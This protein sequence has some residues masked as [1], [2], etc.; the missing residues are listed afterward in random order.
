[1]M[2]APK[3]GGGAAPDLSGLGRS[4]ARLEHDRLIRGRGRYLDDIERP[5]QAHAAFLRSP[6]AHGRLLHIDAAEARALPGVHAVY[7]YADLRAALT[8][9]RIPTA[10]P[11]GSIRF[12]VDPY[13]LS[14]D[15][16]CHVGEPIALVLAESRHVAEDAIALIEVDIEPL[17]VVVDPRAGLE[18]GAPIARQDCPD[19]L[20]AA[21]TAEY[22]D[23]DAAFDGA[24]H[25][26]SEKFHLH[27]GG[28]HSLE[29]RGVVAEWDDAARHLT[30]WDS[31]QMPHRAK[32]ILC[33]SLGLAEDQ[34]R[35][36][37]PDVGGAFGPKFVFHPEELAIPAAA[38]L[39]GRPVKWVEDRFE[40][41]TATVQERD[42]Y[43]TVELAADAE[44][45]LLGV[46]GALIHDHGAYSPYG[47]ALPY[48]SATNLIGP[49]VLP[50]YRLNISLCM[51]N[52]IPSTPTRGAGRPQGTFV[53]ERLLDR[54]AARLGLGRDE[55]RRRNLIAAEKLPYP[56]G[57]RTRDGGE[58]TY[59]S[60]DYVECQRRVLEAADWDGFEA[61]REA[62]AREGRFLG[63][64]LANY[65]EGS[66][67]GPFE[68]ATVS[69]GPS[70][71][72]SVATGA[73]AQGQGTATMLAQLAAARL[74]AEPEDVRIVAG[75]TD[76][77]PN[78]LGAFASRQA[79]TAGNAV[80][81]AAGQV[82]EKLLSVASL[83][84]NAAPEELVLEG[85]VISVAADPE[86]QCA[87][88][89]I[90]RALSGEP[91]YPLPQG[92]APGLSASVDF[93][94]PALT[95]CNGAHVAE[96]EVCPETGVGK[97]L[98]Y[99]VVHD[100]GRLIHPRMVEG[101]ITGGVVHG[102]SSA[103]YEWMGYDQNGQPQTVT[104]ADYLIST[105]DVSPRIEIHHM[106]SPTPLNPL[107]V[108]GAG[109]SGTIA[110]PAAIA[111]A[112]EDALRP[113]GV[114]ITELP[115]TPGRLSDLVRRGRKTA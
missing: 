3:A 107:G 48:N 100:C 97:I 90:A 84:L 52:L 14:C 7:L 16:V 64:G 58:M 43:W 80:H 82:R 5:G 24:A 60:G 105:A 81:L 110:A 69:I 1:M 106:E 9:D 83:W 8:T 112:F 113:F 88:S 65:V 36:I 70:G 41:F 22:G 29:P 4:S 68:S 102:L 11:S 23:V 15:E 49:Y 95:Y 55:L 32:R 61:R 56:T 114:A 21:I 20:V 26:I 2:T 87:V 25:V 74:G 54:L 27:K 28:G 45:R 63:I 53:M 71:R 79:V 108:K 10:M 62:A 34:V 31:T 44:G 78:G 93:Q 104:Y 12:D 47:V 51:T 103:L 86:R 92:V 66:G 42:Q 39:A 94:P 50:A 111:S 59:D 33:A 76:A 73:C 96:V 109:E 6:M 13:V 30:V 40:N 19:N 77:V 101:Q 99:V 35:V 57:L 38:M 85:G 75:D 67:R 98:R 72:V 115:M 18:A 37:A 89:R 17:P 46:R 91:G